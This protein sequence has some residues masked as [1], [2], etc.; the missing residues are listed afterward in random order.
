MRFRSWGWEDDRIAEQL[1]RSR[2]WLS[3]VMML[4]S[5]PAPIRELVRE[6]AISATEAVR[7]IRE[8]GD[9]AAETLQK[10]VVEA[11]AN[12]KAKVTRKAVEAAAI[13][14]KPIGDAY[15]AAEP[16]PDLHPAQVA[17]VRFLE[18][19]DTAESKLA[20]EI[21]VIELRKEV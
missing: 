6:K 13:A 10:A 3:N 7:V 21:A 14:S 9:A 19:W 11:K 12:G 1:Q 17:I 8:Q 20:V 15:V 2:T 16:E 18:I 5:A 4:A